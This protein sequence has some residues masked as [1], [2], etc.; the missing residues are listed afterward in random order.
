MVTSVK[1]AWSEVPD[2][3]G[4]QSDLV[5]KKEE[6]ED[7]GKGEGGSEGRRGKGKEEGR[8]GGEGTEGGDGQI[9]RQTVHR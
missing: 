6:D 5:S 1:R 2:Q 3:P 9:E 4:L 7:R 8:E